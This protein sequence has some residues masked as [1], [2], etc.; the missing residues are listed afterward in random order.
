VSDLAD[1]AGRVASPRTIGS[2]VVVVTPIG[3]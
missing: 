1:G 2:V 3:R